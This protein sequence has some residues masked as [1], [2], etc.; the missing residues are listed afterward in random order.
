MTQTFRVDDNNDF[1]V[2]GKGSFVVSSGLDAVL[3]ACASASKTHLG[4]MI[5]QSNAG[6]P[7]FETVW[8]GT[9]NYSLWQSFLRD[10]LLAIDGV[11]DVVLSISVA[12][13]TLSY[14][15]EITTIYG[16]GTING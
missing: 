5:L 15:A 1:Y 14:S 2:N 12:D 9:P 7:V 6:I 16:T 13:N 10:A 8:N 4:E 11:T 3:Y